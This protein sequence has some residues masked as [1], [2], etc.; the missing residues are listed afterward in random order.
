MMGVGAM[1]GLIGGNAETVEAL[2][3][4][5]G[6]TIA[7]AEVDKENDRLVLR[8]TD[9]SALSASDQGQSC[10]EHRYMTCDD[11]LAPFVGATFVGMELREGPETLD[12]YG[13]PHEQE[14]LL[15]N[16]SAGTFT[17]ANHNEHNGYYGGFS[18]VLRALP[19]TRSLARPRTTGD[20]TTN[21]PPSPNPLEPEDQ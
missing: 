7:A 8:F 15:V 19:P 3:G 11:D 16:T 2:K 18:V 1:M 9:G 12:D 17:V 5:L 20:V 6:K 4:A 14:F 13:G 10:C 21:N